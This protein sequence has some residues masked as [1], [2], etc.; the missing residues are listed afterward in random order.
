MDALVTDLDAKV[1][2]AVTNDLTP[3]ERFRA[4]AEQV[5]SVR[6]LLNNSILPK[7]IVCLKDESPSISVPDNSEALT[8]VRAAARKSGW[9]SCV[10][11]LLSLA[12]PLPAEPEAIE[13]TF[14]VKK[15]DYFNPQPTP[16]T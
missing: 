3:S 10:D 16:V 7:M 2:I 1:I 5:G 14:G 13:A 4:S 8:S 6:E 12:E 15:S 9:D 11:M